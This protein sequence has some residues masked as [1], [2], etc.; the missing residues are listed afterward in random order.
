M[1]KCLSA[2]IVRTIDTPIQDESRTF[3][4]FL[5]K[6]L[7]AAFRFLLAIVSTDDATDKTRQRR[8]KG[9]T[10]KDSLCIE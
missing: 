7:Y 2:A 10:D 5:W 8:D 3:A 4:D 6:L 9:T 1:F